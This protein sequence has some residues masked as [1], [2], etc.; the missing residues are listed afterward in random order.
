M[1]T[2]VVTAT[3]HDGK[4]DQAVAWGAKA[5]G[6]LRDKFPSTNTTLMRNV[7]GLNYQLHWV[8]NVESLAEFDKINKAVLADEGYQKLIGEAI[9]QK[10]FIGS[11]VTNSLYET[12]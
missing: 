8:A 6:Y 4:F 7:A 9:E 12:I 5:A 10:L 2:N 11:S 1:V 3:I